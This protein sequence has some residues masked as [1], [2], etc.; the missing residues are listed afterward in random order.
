[1]QIFCGLLP[2]ITYPIFRPGSPDYPW[3]PGEL[4]IKEALIIRLFP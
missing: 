1:L 4:N 3:L 2:D